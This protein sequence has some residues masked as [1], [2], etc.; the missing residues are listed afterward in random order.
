MDVMPYKAAEYEKMELETFMPAHKESGL[1]KGWGL[2]KVLNHYGYG[3]C[4]SV[5]QPNKRLNF[6]QLNI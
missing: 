2:H 6:N 4:W 5:G 1:R 3:D